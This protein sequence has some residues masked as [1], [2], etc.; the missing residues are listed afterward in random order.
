MTER[1]DSGRELIIIKD[2]A[3]KAFMQEHEIRLRTCG[4]YSPFNVNAAAQAAG[5]AAGE[6]A[7][8]GRPVTGS[9]GALRITS[10]RN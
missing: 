7:T 4:G 10:A 9:G 2:A 3:I 6:R 1:P 5:R 8:F